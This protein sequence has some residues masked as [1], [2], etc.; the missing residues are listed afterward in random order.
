[1]ISSDTFRLLLKVVGM[2]T[3]INIAIATDPKCWTQFGDGIVIGEDPLNDG[4]GSVAYSGDGNKVA[5][6]SHMG[7]ATVRVYYLDKS[8]GSF[9][10][11]GA[12]IKN[13]AGEE[14]YSQMTEAFL[15]SDG[16]IVAIASRTLG[17][18]DS[19]L[20]ARVFGY[21]E[22]SDSWIQRGDEIVR[23]Y[24]DTVAMSPDG[25][26]LAFGSKTGFGYPLV[27]FYDEVSW[28]NVEFNADCMNIDLMHDLSYSIR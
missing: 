12:D 10:P 25:N 24:Y 17:T 27:Y 2:L 6:T 15:S 8:S 1:M 28:S 26:V 21:N 23:S 16:S 4:G 13:A 22:A 3:I 9:T 14:K 19:S 20:I 11:I 18:N 5:V 7:A